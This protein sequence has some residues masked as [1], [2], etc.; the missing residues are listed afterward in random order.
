MVTLFIVID[1]NADFPLQYENRLLPSLL[2]TQCG[3]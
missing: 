3:L 1:A 2:T